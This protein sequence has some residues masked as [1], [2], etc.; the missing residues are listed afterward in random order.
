MSE[1]EETR[2]DTVVDEEEFA[3]LVEG[4]RKYFYMGENVVKALDGVDL[5]VGRGEYVS[6][7]GPSGSGKTTLF[8]VVGGLE[9][10][11]GGQVYIDKTDISKLDAYELAWLRC[12]KIGYIFQSFNLVPIMTALQNVTLPMIFAGLDMKDRNERAAGLL[13]MVGLGDRLHHK[14]TELSGGQMQRVAI[15]RAFANGPA[16][17]LADEPTGNLDLQ[18]GLNI[19]ELLIKMNREL[20]ITILCNT[21]DLKIIEASDRIVWLRDGRINR[22]ERKGEV[23]V[24]VGDIKEA[25]GEK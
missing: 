5:A 13:E 23:Q 14:P 4:V 24:A 15:A 12:R 18:T 7:M 17:V 10:P 11:T 20:G 21:H 8:N 2:L 3:L 22:I 6:I 16:I 19:I 9:K 25:R 1:A